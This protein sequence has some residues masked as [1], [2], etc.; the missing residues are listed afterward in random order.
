MKFT[1]MNGIGNDYIYINCLDENLENPC[2]H[3]KVLS[4]RHFGIGS[5]GIVLI[6]PSLVA[7]FKMEMYNPDGSLAEMCGNAAR[8]IGKYVYDNNLTDKTELTLET[9][10]GIK[11]LELNLENNMVISV[12]VDM[13][14]PIFDTTKIP[15][16]IDMK[17]VI[18]YPLF[19]DK[20]TYNITC[21]SM[22]NPHTV[23]FV[24]DIENFDVEKIG[25]I[26]ER[27]YLF[28]KRTNVEFAKVI[29]KNNI[30]MRV[31]ERG[32]GETLACGTGSCAVLVAA[33]INNYCGREATIHLSGG[34]LFIKWDKS[35]HVF[36]TGTATKVFE[37]II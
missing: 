35:N 16:Y 6:L 20:I 23:I 15:V 10:A 34:D 5:D 12:K 8:C 1:K 32:T 14:I 2:E 7:D 37:G 13:G 27:H 11:K 29:D 4:D 17:E 18:N 25:K 3:S 19:I 9:L 31:W 33:S 26:I 21:I 36:M 30:Q 24:D 22:G 28:P